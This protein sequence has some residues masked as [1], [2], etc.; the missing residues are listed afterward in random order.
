[1]KASMG[2]VEKRTSRL[3]TILVIPAP[4][5]EATHVRLLKYTMIPTRHVEA[6]RV[7]LPKQNTGAIN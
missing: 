5:V 4:H 6:S 2:K 3:I 7:Q 1:M